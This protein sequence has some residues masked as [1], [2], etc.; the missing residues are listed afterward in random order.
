MAER[1]R[2]EGIV[3]DAVLIGAPCTGEPESW[4]KLTRV[5]AGRLI[6]GYC[7][8]DWL[9]K[10]LYRTLSMTSQD[11]A[12]L[13]PIEVNDRRICN[14]DLSEIVSGHSDYPDKICLILRTMKIRVKEGPC[15]DIKMPKAQ[16]MDHLSTNL[17][18][19]V[20]LLMMALEQ[21]D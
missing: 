16:T 19:L 2:C 7:R 21:V 5:V 18:L 1:G 17:K 10:F 11:V 3:Q 14:V 8:T 4:K 12:G 9:L 6:N 13:N 15:G 20:K